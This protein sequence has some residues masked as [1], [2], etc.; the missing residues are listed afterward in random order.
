MLST[1]AIKIEGVERIKEGSDI[2]MDDLTYKL[3]QLTNLFEKQQTKTEFGNGNNVREPIN[4]AIV[5]IIP[6][7]FEALNKLFEFKQSDP[8]I[9]KNGLR[10]W[11]KS[12]LQC[13][14][15]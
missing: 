5:A 12:T 13:T 1:S 3:S 8:E 4:V 2:K 15:C 14:V 6:K 7:E 10:V 11:K 9:I